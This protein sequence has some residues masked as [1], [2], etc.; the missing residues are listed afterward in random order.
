MGGWIGLLA[1][2]AWVW[3]AGRVVVIYKSSFELFFFFFDWDGD[4]T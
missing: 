3:V 4:D 2:L 1:G